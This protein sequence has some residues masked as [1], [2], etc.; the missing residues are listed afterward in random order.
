[1]VTQEREAKIFVLSM[2]KVKFVLEQV[3]DA[4]YADGV[5]LIQFLVCPA[6]VQFLYRSQLMVGIEWKVFSSPNFPGKCL[7]ININLFSS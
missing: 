3:P 2:I 6:Y 4:I 1:M 5:N 7:I